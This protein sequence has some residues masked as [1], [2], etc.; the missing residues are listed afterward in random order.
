[1]NHI[2]LIHSSVDGHLCYFHVSATVNGVAMNIGVHVSFQIMFSSRY[3]PRSGTVRSYG[4]SIFLFF[5][6]KGNSVTLLP[7]DCTN[8]HS[9]QQCGKISTGY[10]F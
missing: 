4:S 9:H 3:M 10:C 5:F 8:L 2:F 6:F 1:M 7:S